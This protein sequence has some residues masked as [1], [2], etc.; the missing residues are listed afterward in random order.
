M[1]GLGIFRNWLPETLSNSNNQYRHR[2]FVE[3]A[4]LRLEIINQLRDYFQNAHEDARR[5]LRSVMNNSL[6]PLEE[7][8]PFDPVDG[9]PERLHVRTLKGYLGEVFAGL[10]SEECS[11]HGEEWEVPAFLFRFHN[12]A[13]SKLEYWRQTGQ[14]P[15]IIPGR[16][17]D[18]C[19][20]FQKDD[21]GQIVRSLFCEAK[22]TSDHDAGMIAKA[23]EQISTD[24]LIP[25]DISR[26]I[27]ILKDYD[28]E[29]SS[30]WI[31]A[32]RY[33]YF[34]LNKTKYE[35]CDLVSYVHGRPPKRPNQ[36]AWMPISAP[37]RNYTGNRRLEA[38]EIRISNVDSLIQ[39]VYGI[40]EDQ[41]D[42]ST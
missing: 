30:R 16:T 38:A 23:H 24:N 42:G 2:L 21:N 10:I 27:E 31:D 34:N 1:N 28:D 17:G 26:I 35:R 18:D 3:N 7:S 39:N 9:Y 37:H 6:D 33:L 36:L 12:I 29:E 11:P 15:R 25:T 13:F 14:T 4:S 20:A 41:N 8:L 32:L 40:G 5:H 19:L 22:C